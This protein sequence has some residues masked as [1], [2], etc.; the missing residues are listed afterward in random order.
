[1]KNLVKKIVWVVFTIFVCITFAVFIFHKDQTFIHRIVALLSV[2][3]AGLFIRFHAILKKDVE[4]PAIY[5]AVIAVLSLITRIIWVLL[6]QV[7]PQSD[8]YTYHSLADAL[9]KGGLLY[10]KFISLFPHVLGYSK[11]L[12]LVYS[13]FGSS[14]S[15][16][17]CLNI[18]LNLGILILLYV[19]GK[20]F[21]DAKTGLVAAAIYAFWPSQIIY[22]ALVLTEPFFTFGALLIITGYFL[23]I[24]K[25]EKTSFLLT[26]F[27]VMGVAAGL[28]KFIRPASL[29]VLLSILIHYLF[30]HQGKTEQKGKLLTLYGTRLALCIVLFLS[31]SLTSSICLNGIDRLTSAKTARNSS[32]FYILVG[33]SQE[34]EGRWN[35]QDSSLLDPMIEKGMTS[36][37]M[38][39]IFTDRGIE[40]LKDMNL[41]S[42]IKLQINKNRHMWGND[43]KSV[44]YVQNSI[45]GTSHVNIAKHSFWLTPMADG[46]YFVF[47]LLSC[48]ALFVAKGK[49]SHDSLVLYLFILGTVAAHMLVE[50]HSRYH[51]TA[52][53]MLCILAAVALTRNQYAFGKKKAS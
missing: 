32:G 6:V 21:Y 17:V 52:V 2:L 14:S 33:L 1:M 8:F 3:A 48:A 12:S 31:Y 44:S 38:Q 15:A 51:Y 5:L 39:Q 36:E 13:I 28:L 49:L 18:L 41:L 22:N 11:V 26:A 35:Q 34:S 23:V 50:V 20:L 27:I 40:R 53:P 4:K 19:L 16:A 42:F 9:A 24:R 37:E 30:I 45:S 29:I 7:V 10:P 47:L 43:S 25:T 46:Y